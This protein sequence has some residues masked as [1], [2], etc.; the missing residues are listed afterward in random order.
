VCFLCLCCLVQEDEV[1]QELLL[2]GG[3]PAVGT[4]HGGPLIELPLSY[5]LTGHTGS[6][7]YMAPEVYKVR[8]GLRVEREKARDLLSYCW[9]TNQACSFSCQHVSCTFPPLPTTLTALLL[10]SAAAATCH[11][12][13]LLPACHPLLLQQHKPYNESV[14]VFSMGVM[15]Y[16]LFSRTLLIY[17]HTPAN[18]PADCETYAARI[19][20][21]FRPKRV[22]CMTEEVWE[23][24]EDCWDQ[25]PG[26]R[27][28]AKEVLTRLQRL[29]AQAQAAEAAKG[30]KGFGK[31]FGGRASLEQ[32]SAAAVTSAQ[33]AGTGGAAVQAASAAPAAQKLADMQPQKAGVEIAGVP[34]REAAHA[35]AEPACGCVIC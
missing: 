35:R 29:L 2:D 24:I 30:P 27:P 11:P 34:G 3:V 7:M 22:K 17:T 10:L 21:G 1:E 18:S 20:E 13:L 33:A 9:C 8:A 15:F 23:L 25:D 26:A 14:D 28:A 6:F 32:Q 5:N 19:S 16:E 31:L 12:L 4:T